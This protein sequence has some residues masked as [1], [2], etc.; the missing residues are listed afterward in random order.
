M[1]ELTFMIYRLQFKKVLMILNNYFIQYF[2]PQFTINS[3]MLHLKDAELLEMVQK[4]HKAAFTILYNRY[5]P[6][7]LTV[8]NRK[9]FNH[10]DAED[11]VQEIFTSFWHRRAQISPRIPVKHYLLRAVHLQYAFKCRNNAVAK[12]YEDYLL[13]SFFNERS[14]DI[15]EY[16]EL[17]QQ[18]KMAIQKISAPACKKIFELAY[19]E[20]RSCSEIALNLDIGR[21]VVRNQTSRALK[22]IREQLKKII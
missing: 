15:L 11:I 4:N 5:Q 10:Q 16:K 2:S 14:A 17:G 21:Q 1:V 12:K 18:I 6:I 7:M 3:I 9:L 8:A 13:S 22:I 20:D 19:L